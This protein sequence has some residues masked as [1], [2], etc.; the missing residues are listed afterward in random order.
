MSLGAKYPTVRAIMGATT[1]VVPP[2]FALFGLSNCKFPVPNFC[3][4]LLTKHNVGGK[5]SNSPGCDDQ[6][7]TPLLRFVRVEQLQIPVSMRS[8]AL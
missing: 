5:V 7:S 1:K 6:G 2:H 8:P 3:L 4:K